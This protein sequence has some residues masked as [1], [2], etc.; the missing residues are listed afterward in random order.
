MICV[1]GCHT[2]APSSLIEVA[3]PQSIRARLGPEEA[4]RLSEYTRS[5]SRSVEGELVETSA[6]SVMILIAVNSRL[7]GDRVQT[8]HQRVQVARSGIL[9]V[10]LKE[11]N[12]PRT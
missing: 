10:E 9:D 12:R 4:E 8:F 11:L 2:Y 1:A 5:N 7:R 6:D 3:P